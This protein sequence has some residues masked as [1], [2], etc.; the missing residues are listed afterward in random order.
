MI[1]RCSQYVGAIR[2]DYV[3]VARCINI[4]MRWPNGGGL[5]DDAVL[6]Q[7][8]ANVLKIEDQPERRVLSWATQS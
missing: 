6:S 5:A 3:R 7:G 4:T 2:G 1:S 8:Y